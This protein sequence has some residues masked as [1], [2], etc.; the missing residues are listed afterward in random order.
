[1]VQ[2][3]NVYLVTLGMIIGHLCCTALAVIGGRYISMKISAKHGGSIFLLRA[4]GV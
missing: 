2:L 1:M 4:T 3:Q